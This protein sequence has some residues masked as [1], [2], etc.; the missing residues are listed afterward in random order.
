MQAQATMP[1]PQMLEIKDACERLAIDYCFFADNRRFDEFAALFAANGEMT[2]AGKIYCG[3]EAI[4]AAIDEPKEND[5][6]VHI[7]ANHRIDV[8]SATEAE[9]TVYVTGFTGQLRDGNAA[10][11]DQVTTALV[12][13]YYDSYRKTERGWRFAYRRFKPFIAILQT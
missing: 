6:T 11:L 1:P 2:L 8:L 12:G 4:R 13:I 10:G 5:F 7:V 3:S 9:G